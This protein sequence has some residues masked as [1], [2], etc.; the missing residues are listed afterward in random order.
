[1][2]KNYERKVYANIQ[3]EPE[4]KRR[5]K[6]FCGR[7]VTA[8]S[9]INILLNCIEKCPVKPEDPE[10]WGVPYQHLK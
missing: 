10:F 4:T 3:V 7:R 5:F 1:M 8:D 2:C 9:G 6:E